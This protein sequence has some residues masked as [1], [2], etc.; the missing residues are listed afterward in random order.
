MSDLEQLKK[1]VETAKQE[2]EAALLETKNEAMATIN[3]AIA[4]LAEL[5][6]N[7]E[8]VD[9]KPVLTRKPNK[10]TWPG[11]VEDAMSQL[12]KQATFHSITSKLGLAYK[13]EY[14]SCSSALHSLKRRGRLSLKDGY[15]SLLG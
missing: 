2:L 8:L 11:R 14:A 15:Y 9:A 10:G 4:V 5:G 6:F 13:S 7:Y 1:N 12:G 3:A